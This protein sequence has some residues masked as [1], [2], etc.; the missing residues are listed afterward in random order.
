MS[1]QLAIDFDV[2]RAARDEGM[3]R[4]A[5]HAERVQGG[6]KDAAFAFLVRYAGQHARFI[7]EEATQ[8]AEALGYG[9]P[10]D[11]RAWGAIFQRAA[12]EGVIRRDG[13]GISKRRHLSPTPMWVS[14]VAAGAQDAAPQANPANVKVAAA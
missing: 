14:C 1:A 4:A 9:A 8:A 11:S 5:D 7:S 10:T 3:G 13:F 6:W 2:A 12:R